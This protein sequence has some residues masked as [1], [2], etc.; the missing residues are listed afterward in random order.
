MKFIRVF[1]LILVALGLNEQL[2][3]QTVEFMVDGEA[4]SGFV[5][6]LSA[7]SQKAYVFTAGHCLPGLLDTHFPAKNI[8]Q[9][10]IVPAK[11]FLVR[12]LKDLSQTS[13]VKVSNI[14]FASFGKFDVAV[15]DSVESVQNLEARGVVP[16]L[17]D[18]DQIDIGTPVQIL[19]PLKQEKRICLIESH[20]PKLHY[21]FWSWQY[22]SRLSKECKLTHGW[23]GAVVLN[24]ITGTATGV[25]SG[26]NETGNCDDYCEFEM[27]GAS[28]A[29]KN[30][31]YVT[32]LTFLKPCTAQSGVFDPS[33]CS[34]F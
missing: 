1:V 26:G 20:V 23:S 28:R 18:F 34:L 16:I 19:N 7:N 3:A 15:L 11:N 32:R 22:T 29:F 4:C 33:S 31:S 2:S 27:N 17:V 9:T 12:H 8:I 24:Q 21:Q 25:V 30:Q 13:W 6:K 14:V 10:P 5:G